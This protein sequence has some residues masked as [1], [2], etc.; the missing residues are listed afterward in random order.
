[1][2]STNKDDAAAST[3]TDESYFDLFDD[4]EDDAD[5]GDIK[6]LMKSLDALPD[7][8]APLPEKI[9][10]ALSQSLSQIAFA[11]NPDD[12]TK[13]GLSENAR[14]SLST[15]SAYGHPLSVEEAE[16]RI[17]SGAGGLQW[18]VMLINGDPFH[19]DG[20][21][22]KGLNPRDFN[23][24]TKT[25][26]PRRAN[27]PI[28]ATDFYSSLT[29]VE[30]PDDPRFIFHGV[31]NGWPSLQTFEVVKIER[32]RNK[33]FV[34]PSEIIKGQR[35]WVPIWQAEVEG[36]QRLDP[37]ITESGLI[38]RLTLRGPGYT[39]KGWSRKSPGFAFW[40]QAQLRPEP[41]LTYGTQ[42]IDQM[43]PNAICTN[44]HM[45]AHMYAR[46]KENAK[47]KLTYHSCVLLEWN[48]QEYCTVIEAAWLN[49]LAGW[50]G[51]CNF[52]DDMDDP[53]TQMYKCFPPEMVC[54]WL[55][56]AAEIRAFDVE[57]KTFDEFKGYMTK[58][59]S[60]DKRFWD[61]QYPFSHP[62]RLTYRSKKDIAQ[63]LV[64][65]M[66]RDVSYNELKRNCQ[67]LSADLCN[68]VAGKNNVKPFHPVNRIEYK[69]RSYL[70]LY[71][72]DMYDQQDEAIQA[73]QL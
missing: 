64:N 46:V 54:P 9:E 63:Y 68:F 70:F 44:V 2:S 15:E 52:Y 43:D 3:A 14:A 17:P 36:K 26:K 24:E 21:L 62:A 10:R 61:A 55:T 27:L 11:A 7:L 50:R 29:R 22:K 6:E 41:T 45:V 67:T 34:R 48:H 47:D 53:V 71:D 40:Y 31:L 38:F 19:E 32:K 20:N 16:K 56:N 66:R 25:I 49:G 69:N 51:K 58:Y 30:G 60:R 5:K 35:V 73:N 57:S 33:E 18:H 13:D 37:T 4:D 72:P 12:E 23:L 42:M 39:S 1:M 59:E 28:L 8:P 65:Y